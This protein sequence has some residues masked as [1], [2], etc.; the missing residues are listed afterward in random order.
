MVVLLLAYGFWL[1]QPGGELDQ[2]ALQSSEPTV[3]GC[4]KACAVLQRRRRD[5]SIVPGFNA[6]VEAETV[7]GMLR[8]LG[9]EVKIF[10]KGVEQ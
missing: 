4:A 3:K 5:L 7:A 2:R 8:E 6:L 10:V 9:C 1:N